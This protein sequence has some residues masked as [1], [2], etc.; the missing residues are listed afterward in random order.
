MVRRKKS[1]PSAADEPAVVAART[2]KDAYRQ[3]HDQFGSDAVILGSRT[4][5]RR[6]ELGLGQERFVEVMVQ[7]PGGR[8]R[9][10]LPHTTGGSRL[11]QGNSSLSPAPEN[12]VLPPPEILQEV[13]R[14]EKLVHELA[15]GQDKQLGIS[16]ALRDN[17]V[18]GALVEG[19]ASPETVAKLMTRFTGETGKQATESAAVQIWLNENMRASN[20]DWDGFRGC[21]AFLGHSGC[22]RTNLVLNSA[23]RLQTMGQSVLV[24]SVFP[25][26]ECAIKELQLAAAEHG[27]DGAIIQKDRQLSS[28]NDYLQRYDVVLVDLPALSDATLTMGGTTHDWL[29]RH[30]GFHRHL[31]V[32]LDADLNDQVD[33]GQTARTW[34]CDW[35]V[36]TRLDR[37]RRPG[38]ILDLHEMI[39]LPISLTVGAPGSDPGPGIARSAELVDWILAEGNLQGQQ[40]V[41][42]QALA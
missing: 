20:C 25:T 12:P 11:R 6:Q 35:L 8:A 9:T 40:S 7:T 39:P 5:V 10:D 2:L 15:E 31:L 19:G 29:A 37:T 24:L 28:V 41:R 16:L 4:V 30:E 22:G 32:P 1:K 3:V 27:F 18:A 26:D 21:H 33:L 14:I 23:A 34:N 42:Q 36:L 13:E 17:P 38:K